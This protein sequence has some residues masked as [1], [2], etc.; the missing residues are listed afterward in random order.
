MQEYKQTFGLRFAVSGRTRRKYRKSYRRRLEE[1]GRRW[2]RKR[3]VKEIRR[4][5]R[6]RR[7]LS[8][9]RAVQADPHLVSAG[10]RLFGSWRAAVEAAGISYDSVRIP[11]FWDSDRII[12]WIKD[13]HRLGAPVNAKAAHRQGVYAAACR[14]FE[15]WDAALV[16]AGVDPRDVRRDVKFSEEEV[17]AWVRNRLGAGKSLRKGDVL[18]EYPRIVH[19]VRNQFGMGWS[20][21]LRKWGFGYEYKVAWSKA[22]IREKIG[23]RVRRGRSLKYSVVRK[24]DEKLVSA[25]GKHFRMGWKELIQK[26]GYEYPR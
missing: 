12:G 20:D 8:Y 1:E 9:K 7:P 17:I 10:T 19:A 22:L 5:S 23:E 14:R 13:R 26:L 4:A 3:V 25:A 24:E 21:A 16:A 15:S 18:R 6:Q 2:T 11:R